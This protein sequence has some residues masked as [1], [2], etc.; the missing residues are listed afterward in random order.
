MA[1]WT[2]S[3]VSF[4]SA[5]FSRSLERS[6]PLK[7]SS[8]NRVSSAVDFSELPKNDGPGNIGIVAR[9]KGTW[10]IWCRI[11]DLF[12]NAPEP[13]VMCSSVDVLKL[14]GII[15]HN[16]PHPVLRLNTW[17]SLKLSVNGDHVIFWINGKKIVETRE[18]AIL[19]QKA[20]KIIQKIPGI[21]LPPTNTGKAGFGLA[22]LYG[23]IR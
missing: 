17:S 20:Q 14:I 2:I 5:V 3:A 16:E 8:R 1:I 13:K 10:A 15:F 19:R 21:P 11:T 23:E 6:Y 7:A 4:S 9:V 22:G 12:L 18:L